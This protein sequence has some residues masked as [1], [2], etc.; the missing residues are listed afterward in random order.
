MKEEK[1]KVVFNPNQ[2]EILVNFYPLQQ[3]TT[4]VPI[5]YYEVPKKSD[6]MFETS[7][8]SEVLVNS[9]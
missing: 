4:A 8:V 9:D 7:D 1:I 6:Q 5:N 3:V 2:N